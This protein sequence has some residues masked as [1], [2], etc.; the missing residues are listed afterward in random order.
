MVVRAQIAGFPPRPRSG[1][2]ATAIADDSMVV[3]GGSVNHLEC[4]DV[5]LFQLVHN[6]GASRASSCAQLPWVPLP[7]HRP[8]HGGRGSTR[9]HTRTQTHTCAHTRTHTHVRTRNQINTRLP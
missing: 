1:H 8:R 6:L 9:M 4:N 3:F 5:Y 2:S 7:L